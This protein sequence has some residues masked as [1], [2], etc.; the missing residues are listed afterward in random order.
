MHVDQT[1]Q[2]QLAARVDHLGAGGGRGSGQIGAEL[3]HAAVRRQQVEQGIHPVGRI[4]QPAA[5]HQNRLHRHPALIAP[6][7][8]TPPAPAA[9][10]ASGSRVNVVWNS[11]AMRTATPLVT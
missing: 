8:R 11:T 5:P 10:P 4:H 9:P 6:A 3:P 1:G 7:S 2:H